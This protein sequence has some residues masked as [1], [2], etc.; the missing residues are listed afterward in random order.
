MSWI[1]GIII[2][3]AIALAAIIAYTLYFHW[4][5]YKR[6][7]GE[8]RQLNDE[9]AEL[10]LTAGE[11]DV[12][13]AEL[14]R[15]IRALQDL[16]AKTQTLE[17]RISETE[18][19]RETAL[20][21]V[22]QLREALEQSK[23]RSSELSQ[24]LAI[25][26][27]ELEGLE[28]THQA[29]IGELKSET[30]EKADRVA[31]LE[32]LLQGER[33]EYG[34]R[35]E[36][37][38]TVVGQRDRHIEALE[39]QGKGLRAAVG[40]MR[41]DRNVLLAEKA[42]VNMAFQKSRSRV[43]TL[44]LALAARERELEALEETHQARIGELKSE[45][46]EK[47]NRVSDLE[48]LLQR[49]RGEYG[50]R[51]QGLEVLVGQRD[52]RIAEFETEGGH[53][54]EQ[55]A[56]LEVDVESLLREKDEL[57]RQLKESNDQV[58]GLSREIVARQNSLEN[59]K[60]AQKGLI[61]QLKEQIQ[62]KEVQVSTLQEKLRIR[63]LD[64]IL[65]NPGNAVVTPRGREVLSRVATE[66]KNLSGTR[67]HVEG[68]TDNLPLSADARAVYTDNLGLSAARAAA[69]V[70]MLRT[71]GVG[72]EVLSAAG[73]SMYRPLADNATPEGR[74]QNRRVEVILIPMD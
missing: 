4:G 70:R 5:P 9:I 68:H 74:R 30:Q 33:G 20:G 29:R 50:D 72:P 23:N 15:K 21:E 27:Q 69:V 2:V 43:G 13:K 14:S 65:F 18:G 3:L 17:V 52:G 10:R 71:R 6:V 47:A 25:M 39:R 48:R 54:K 59:V 19:E 34:Q 7:S 60:E 16:E 51:I 45:T 28:E 35:I 36:G 62:Q 41:G 40:T 57:G 31:G 24:Q 64:R 55:V 49:E 46:Q 67:I 53:L 44:S 8:N 61:E 42:L 11:L 37:L 12:V 1:K 26:E 66:L 63:F 73:Y 32:R 38:E 58:Q 56:A 22:V